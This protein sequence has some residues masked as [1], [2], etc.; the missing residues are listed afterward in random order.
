MDDV[1]K[2]AAVLDGS[3]ECGIGVN[4][5]VHYDG[6]D[7]HWSRSLTTIIMDK[8]SMV[9]ETLPPPFFCKSLLSLAVARKLS[10]HKID[11]FPNDKRQISLLT[12]RM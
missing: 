4:N 6:A 5:N 3:D 1:I 10:I 9:W 12:L 8:E 11:N 2:V 7:G